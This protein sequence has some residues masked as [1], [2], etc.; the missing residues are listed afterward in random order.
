MALFRPDISRIYITLSKKN[1]C[2]IDYDQCFMCRINLQS[3]FHE[4]VSVS[5]CSINPFIARTDVIAALLYAGADVNRFD[6]N[7][8]TPL[9]YACR[10]DRY[11]LVD[12]FLWHGNADMYVR[13][14]HGL[15]AIDYCHLYKKKYN[16]PCV[17]LSAIK[18]YNQCYKFMLILFAI[19][20]DP[21]CTFHPSRVFY[22][23]FTYLIDNFLYSLY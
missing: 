9:M 4:L 20:S 16:K 5:K 15:S 1:H 2:K 18:R 7:G 12:I 22:D 14:A 19:Q 3:C 6:S 17:S 11:N 10:I 21:S 23:I 8:L 13:D